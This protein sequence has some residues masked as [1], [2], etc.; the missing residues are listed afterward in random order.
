VRIIYEG[1][2][3]GLL[4]MRQ[5]EPLFGDIL[6]RGEVASALGLEASEMDGRFPA[7]EVSTGLPF[8]IVPLKGLEALRKAKIDKDGYLKLIEGREGKA[9]LAFSPETYGGEN[10]LS[11]RMFADFY[12]IPEDPATGSG[13]GCLAGYLVRHLYFGKDRVEL[14]V[15]Q[16]YEVGRPSLLM[17]KGERVGGRI[18]VEVGGRVVPFARGRLL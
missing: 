17:L 14:R 1:N 6:E 9:V 8:V 18:A 13:G 7:Q 2:E 4:V 3:P 12:G 15:E 5:G 11:V 16:G 10:H